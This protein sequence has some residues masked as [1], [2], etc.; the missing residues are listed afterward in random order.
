MRVI[1]RFSVDQDTNGSLT[2]TLRGV[3]ANHGIHLNPNVTA[4]YEGNLDQD[5][6]AEAM[7]D[8]WDQAHSFQTTAGCHVDHFW[9]YAD[10]PPD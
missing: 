10:N 9:M 6:L 8:F 5:D 7:T 4:T 2:N 3:L 1:V